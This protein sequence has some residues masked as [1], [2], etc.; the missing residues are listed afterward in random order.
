MTEPFRLHESGTG[1]H[2]DAITR[3]AAVGLWLLPLHAALL[4]LSTLT[5]QPDPA[6]DFEGYARYIT[7]DVFLLSHLVA[8]I[9]GA[10]LGCV[11]AV[12]ALGFLV[13]SRS[14]A[15][16]TLG[17]VLFIVAN[18]LLTAIFSAAAFTQPA[19]GR[20]F[21]DGDAGMRALNDDVY[22]TPLLL[23]ALFALLLFSAAGI[24]LGKAFAGQ[25]TLR[26]PGIVYAVALPTFAIPGFVVGMF[27]PIAAAAAAV[28][29][30]L[31]AIRL[32]RVV[33]SP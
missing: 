2:D 32:P 17:T 19:I 12:A 24:L 29:T 9:G 4:A 33:R 28:A 27:Q 20:A 10:A 7:T 8:S 23:T 11:G 6:T 16:A 1:K 31:V 18:V 25:A 3:W 26:W 21:L 15:V 22:G 13:R 30:V 14:A 5:H